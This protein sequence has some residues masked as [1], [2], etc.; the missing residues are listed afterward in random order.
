[1]PWAELGMARNASRDVLGLRIIAVYGTWHSLSDF[2][3]GTEYKNDDLQ[4]V[5]GQWLPSVVVFQ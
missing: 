3:L 1:M 2:V 4:A 5:L